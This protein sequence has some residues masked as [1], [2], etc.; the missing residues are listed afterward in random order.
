M[1]ANRELLRYREL[2]NRLYNFSAYFVAKSIT[3][4]PFQLLFTTVFT[5]LVYFIVGFQV[6]P[7]KKTRFYSP[8]LD[9]FL[10]CCL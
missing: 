9:L 2:S 10:V 8:F 6:R 3:S 4:L 5:L 7:G 1:E